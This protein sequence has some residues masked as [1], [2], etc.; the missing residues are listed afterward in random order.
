MSDSTKIDNE[1]VIILY[2]HCHFIGASL[3]KV[4]CA[5]FQTFH[6]AHTSMYKHI[7]AYIFLLSTKMMPSCTNFSE[8]CFHFNL[9]VTYHEYPLWLSTHSNHSFH[10]SCIAIF[11]SMESTQPFLNWWVLVSYRFFPP[12]CYG[13]PLEIFNTICYS[14]VLEDFKSIHVKHSLKSSKPQ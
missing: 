9:I 12:K 8:T 13:K 5:F 2:P 6:C 7:Y 10:N 11:H 4:C 1:K 14:F 3:I